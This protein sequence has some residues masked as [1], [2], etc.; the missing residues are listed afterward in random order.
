MTQLDLQ[1]LDR[2]YFWNERPKAVL[3]DLSNNFDKV[4]DCTYLND[5]CPSL[6]INDYIRLFLPNSIFD[7]G[8][9]TT[10]KYAV[11]IDETHTFAGA[12]FYTFDEL[13]HAVEKID[14]LLAEKPSRPPMYEVGI[15]RGESG[16]ETLAKFPTIYDA[17]T[18]MYGC[19][20]ANPN[21]KFF[22]DTITFDYV[23]T[24]NK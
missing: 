4:E 11:V 3:Q 1:S 16:T 14:E 12:K 13:H 24:L 2:H 9:T 17:D 20:M 7:N 21:A 8:E 19:Q 15:D 18:F 22:I 23:S 10:N 6:V 5:T